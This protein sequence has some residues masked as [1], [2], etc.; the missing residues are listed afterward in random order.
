MAADATLKPKW[1]LILGLLPSINTSLIA[2][3]TA[4]VSIGGTLAT[5]HY[6][7]PKTPF[8]IPAADKAKAVSPTP[9]SELAFMSA[10][11]VLEGR[12]DLHEGTLGLCVSEV[13]ALRK[14]RTDKVAPIV[15]PKPKPKAKAAVGALDGIA[16]TVFGKPK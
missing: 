2:I 10:V 9:V 3:V 8:L 14:E 4:A 7:A 1:Q 15:P 5:Q 16:V 13:Q 6:A 12:M 11:K